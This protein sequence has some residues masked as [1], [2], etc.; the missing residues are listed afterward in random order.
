MAQDRRQ[1]MES[2]LG[3]KN[4]TL[5]PKIRDGEKI[6]FETTPR[7]PIHKNYYKSKSTEK[8]VPARAEYRHSNSVSGPDLET[9]L[10]S[11]PL[12]SSKPFSTAP[13]SPIDNVNS[14]KSMF[15][16]GIPKLVPCNAKPKSLQ[17]DISLP[18]SHTEVKTDSFSPSR[19]FSPS[20]KNAEKLPTIHKQQSHNAPPVS[21]PLSDA[22]SP[23]D[24]PRPNSPH[25]T[26]TR[27]QTHHKYHNRSNSTSEEGHKSDFNN[28]RYQNNRRNRTPSGRYSKSPGRGKTNS[29]EDNQNL[30]QNPIFHT[31]EF[32]PRGDRF[33]HSRGSRAQRQPGRRKQDDRK[34]NQ[35][36]PNPLELDGDGTELLND[37]VFTP[38]D[39]QLDGDSS[40]TLQINKSDVKVDPIIS[41][42]A[43][44]T[45]TDPIDSKP[46][47]NEDTKSIKSKSADDTITKPINCKQPVDTGIR[48]INS[49]QTDGVGADPS[50]SGSADDAGTGLIES[51]QTVDT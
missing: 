9:D 44:G 39:S 12:S 33:S 25:G 27:A 26:K 37:M 49:K 17:L 13:C 3:A 7:K 29:Q 51:K 42:P 50:E 35:S 18:D 20:G 15:K 31:K 43:D 8:L 14:S 38:T 5:K 46:T 28:Q 45:G 10:A 40:E 23:L 4:P 1:S 41:K 24:V 19:E 30:D 22:T 11:S 16:D 21:S 34:Q 6:L 2:R 36:D 48:T 32:Y 47:D